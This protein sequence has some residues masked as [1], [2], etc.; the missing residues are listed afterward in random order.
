MKLKGMRRN[1][2]TDEKFIRSFQLG[3]IRGNEEQRT[4]EASLSSEF[5]VKRRRGMEILV[6]SMEAVDLSRSPL[7]LIVSHDDK[8]LPV[9]IV[10]GLQVSEGKLRG[11]IRFG[12][13]TRATEVWQDV[14]AGILRN[15]SIG[16]LPIKSEPN[17]PDSYRVT[18]WMPY[19]ASLLAAPADPT[20]G[21]GR[22]FKTN[23]PKGIKMDRNDLL[24]AKKRAV[25]ALE[26]LTK[27]ESLTDDD[28]KIADELKTEI[29]GYERRL[30]L[31]DEVEKHQGGQKRNL[32][33]ISGGRDDPRRGEI[34]LLKREESIAEHV[35]AEL[36]DGI[37]PE[38][39]SLGRMVRGFVTGDWN[40]AE[41]ERRSVMEIGDSTLGGHLVPTP[42]SA[43]IIDMAR[44]KSVI[45]RAGALTVPMTASTL[46][47]AKI[48]QDV[49]GYWRA[50]NAAI[51]ESNMVFDGV[52]LTCKVLAALCRISIEL[53]E[54]GANVGQLIE[55][56]IA[57]ALALELD[58]VC[59][60]GSGSGAEPKGLFTYT[61]VQEI[62]MG[63]NG[64]AIA[65]YSKFSQGIQKLY[66]V[67][68]SPGAIV[69][70]PRTWGVLD[71]LTDTTDQ[72]LQ[73]PESYRSVPKIVSNQI[74]IN[75]TQGTANNAS[76][77][78]IG[79]WVNMLVG[80]R[81]SLVIEASR[82]AESDSFSKMQVLI[83]GYLRADM[84]LARANHFVRVKGIIPA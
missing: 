59:L 13:S 3:E 22:S 25:D 9:G 66:E 33:S 35:R 42:L 37:K 15:L 54:D 71:L 6:H 73:A 58:R 76:C 30:S 68:A 14:K 83:R 60:V 12:S 18:R 57:A 75:Q 47:L 55:D 31:L 80:M 43:R 11:T 17:G 50:E 79:D 8:E 67:N 49:T 40:Q 70:A 39:L 52:T 5:P 84:Q 53:M 34:R 41:A 45:M 24:K 1:L 56:S 23:E 27:R 69:F 63:D 61:G 4:V 16:Y 26:A 62:S 64:A 77:A 78:F 51:T 74:P 7:P 32:P 81:T 82:V 20:V 48:T 28:L 44:N 72:P 21:I 2:Q 65:D 19:E 36:P 46:K 38:E 29:A 10:E